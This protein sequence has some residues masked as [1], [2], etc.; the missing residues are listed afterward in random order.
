MRIQYKLNFLIIGLLFILTV[1]VVGSVSHMIGEILGNEILD[2]EMAITE[3]MACDLAIPILNKDVTLIQDNIYNLKD[4]NVKVKYI[5][6][7]GFDGT[8][9]ASTFDDGFPVDLITTNTISADENISIQTLSA[10]AKPI[11]DIGV[12]VLE[13]MDA[14]VHIGFSREYLLESIT[15]TTNLIISIGAGILVFGICLSFFLTRRITSPIEELVKGTKRVGGG[16]FDFRIDIV[17]N[18]EIG[19]LTKSFNQ[20]IAER[21]VAEDRIKASLNEK[22]VLMREIHHRVKNNLQVVSSMLNLQ[23]RI[24]KDTAAIDVLS[25]SRNR[26]EVMALIHSQLY[27]SE[28]LSEINMKKFVDKLLNQLLLNYSV[29]D[30]KITKFVSVIDHPF[31]ISIATPIG[32]IINELLSNVLKHAFDNR[33]KG[34]IEVILN[35]SEKN[36]INLTI[37]DDGIG[38]PE[39]F[40][41]NITKTLGLRLVKILVEHQ[42][43]GILEVISKEGTTFNIEFDMGDNDNGK[44]ENINSRR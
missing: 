26:I 4:Q 27:E 17:S 22:E 39:G 6:I 12:R 29:R 21:K 1:L 9:I 41:I 34:I 2:K 15:R 33:K 31:P 36:T 37:S 10:N 25:E 20:M 38:L 19:I 11:Q 16:D 40:D 18:D 14:K 7:V 3:H 42:L 8:V 30:T 35:K 28:N 13:D 23:A 24:T 44:S 43:Q 32:L 5:Y